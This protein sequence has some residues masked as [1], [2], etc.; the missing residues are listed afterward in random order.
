MLPTASFAHSGQSDCFLLG[1]VRKRKSATKIWQ[2]SNVR[3]ITKLRGGQQDKQLERWAKE[4]KTET[5]Q[6]L[7]T[8]V[9]QW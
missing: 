1:W 8:G 9:A 4:K 3:Q 5:S 2:L 6:G 7:A